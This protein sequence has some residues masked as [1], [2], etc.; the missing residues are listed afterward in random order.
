MPEEIPQ[1]PASTWLRNII[2][3]HPALLLTGT[4][5]LLSAIGVM[6]N[7]WLFSNFKINVL[8]YSEPS[9]FLMAAIREPWIIVI[10]LLPIPI[11]RWLMK[12]DRWM[13]RKFPRYDRLSNRMEKEM[14][15]RVIYLVAVILWSIAFT[16]EF[17]ERVSDRIKAGQSRFVTVNFNAD[18]R[19]LPAYTGRGI[20]I[21]TTG[22]YVFLHYPAEHSTHIVPTEMISS[23]VVTRPEKKDDAPGVS[24]AKKAAPAPPVSLPS[25]TPVRTGSP[26]KAGQP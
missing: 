1:R 15:S 19:P 7:V 13:R 17:A 12:S 9:D 8:Y 4:Y 26:K 20:L 23:I 6:Y 18:A 25:A 14:P 2:E 21:G 3:Q 22:R 10:S 24:R 5:L 11:L 16:A